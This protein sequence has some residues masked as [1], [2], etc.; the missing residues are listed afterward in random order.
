M[1]LHRQSRQRRK[2]MKEIGEAII[3]SE[4]VRRGDA[5]AG[6]YKSTTQT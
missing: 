6:G 5:R 2:S 1:T 3:L 4:A